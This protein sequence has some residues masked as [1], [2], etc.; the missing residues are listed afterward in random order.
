MSQ[1]APTTVCSVPVARMSYK[2]FAKE[3]FCYETF[4]LVFIADM[5]P[6]QLKKAE[7]KPNIAR[8]HNIKDS[9]TT[10]LPREHAATL[11]EAVLI[12]VG[13]VK[14]R[15]CKRVAVVC[16]AGCNR[17]G[18]LA[19][20]LQRELAGWTTRVE[21]HFPPVQSYYEA[22]V[23]SKEPKML[24]AL[25]N[26]NLPGRPQRGGDGRVA[27]ASLESASR[28][29]VEWKD[30]KFSS[31]DQDI[32]IGSAAEPVAESKPSGKRKANG[33]PE[34]LENLN[35]EGLLKH[36]LTPRLEG[37]T[38]S[39]SARDT[40]LRTA[41]EID[42]MLDHVA[43]SDELVEQIVGNQKLFKKMKRAIVAKCEKTVLVMA[44]G[45]DGICE[46]DS[47]IAE[48]SQLPRWLQLFVLA[49]EEP[50]SEETE[51]MAD[52]D[53]PRFGF[54]RTL[55]LDDP[56]AA[57]DLFTKLEDRFSLEQLKELAIDC[58][59]AKR[60]TR[61]DDDDEEGEEDD[62]DE[63]GEEDDESEKK[64]HYAQAIREAIDDVACK[65]LDVKLID[66]LFKSTKERNETQA[67]LAAPFLLVRI[68]HN[69]I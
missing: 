57:S 54:M 43:D 32:S 5:T 1:P 8:I 51:E 9:S 40:V 62:D 31:F 69:H 26:T 34:S 23:A 11:C 52:E 28:N 53:S 65:T 42:G 18:L 30:F 50:L 61:D 10:K 63:E 4:Y 17:S 56:S 39:A 41:F 35:M 24:D 33:E 60:Y 3:P 47:C 44:G 64:E 15:M 12:A 6:E 27:T 22:I 25:L 46:S 59:D 14:A 58:C 19:S 67:M 68:D 21:L 66:D 29:T 55:D 13:R 38:T 49:Y 20:L 36:F 45:A 7:N 37:A 48:V 2:L 16:A